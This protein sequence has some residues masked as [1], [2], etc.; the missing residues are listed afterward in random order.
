MNVPLI[1][2]EVEHMKH[3][4]VHACSVYLAKMDA[5]IQDAVEKA[6]TVENITRIVETAAD[7]AISKAIR[8]EIDSYFRFGD[9]RRAI[10]E[11]VEKQLSQ[12]KQW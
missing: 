9:G 12:R 2:L 5:Q 11:V 8:E 7:E 10:K 3:S 4:M 1:R 6:C